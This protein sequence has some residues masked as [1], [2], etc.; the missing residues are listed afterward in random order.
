MKRFEYRDYLLGVLLVGMASNYVDRVALG[1]LLQ[2]IKADLSLSDTQLGVLSGIA[3]ALFYSIVGLPIA[4]WAD[5]GNRVV[6]MT[7]ATALWSVSVAL[8]GMAASFVHLLLIRVVVAIGEAGFI[9]PAHSMMADYFHRAERP[10]AVAIFKLGIPAS[11]VVG[12]L[13][14]GWLN[15]LYG[16]RVT[17]ALIGAPGVLLAALIW[18]TLREPRRALPLQAPE[19]VAATLTSAGPSAT[20]ALWEVT[21]SLLTNK[22]F[23]HLLMAYSLA[24]V[25]GW[26]IA[27]WQPAF[28]R[29]THGL[30]T[31]EL[32][33]W[34]TL[35]WGAGGFI[36][37]YLG[38]FLATR[39]FA[40]REDVQLF[41]MALAYCAFGVVMTGVYLSPDPY[42]AFALMGIAFLGG[43]A[44]NGPMFATLQS[45]VPDR[46]RAMSVAIIFLFSN[47]IG[48][49]LG[50]LAAGALSDAL[51]PSFGQ[52]SLRY[53][54]MAL[55]PGYL[56]CGWHLWRASQSVMVDLSH[57][58]SGTDAT[59]AAADSDVGKRA[60]PIGP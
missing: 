36:G 16:W 45:L 4:R 14:A 7:L 48:A 47:L 29:R 32:G 52:E 51:R 42:V 12:Y 25:F 49:G 38:G 54:L 59:R 30:E 22:T 58:R 37:T 20:P 27:N 10:R 60:A 24:A 56:W 57:T 35:V 19:R 5:R 23:L 21:R 34:M 53:A 40:E 3:F 9:P 8:C 17:F 55:C 50:P 15:Q 28:F 43:S 33:M 6:I 2:D 44:G 41:A 18:F 1:L 31:G 39:Y 13:L 11:L 46:M 26:G